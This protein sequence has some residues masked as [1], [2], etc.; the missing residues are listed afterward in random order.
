MTHLFSGTNIEY[1]HD[2]ITRQVFSHDA[3]NYCIEPKGVVFPK[4]DTEVMTIIAKA[5]EHQLS[6]IPRGAATG[7][8]GGCLGSGLI[9][10]TSKHMNQILEINR[11]EGWVKC[12]PGV[13]Q[14]HLN[15]ALSP[16]RLGPDTSTGNRATIG[17]MVGNNAAGSYSL[18]YGQMIDHVLEIEMALSTGKLI[19]FKNPSSTLL[20]SLRPYQ[21]EIERRFPKIK[22]HVSGYNLDHFLQDPNPCKLIVGSEGT[23][24][25]ITAIK[26]K[27]VPRP[28]NIKLVTIPF[29]SLEKAFSAIPD[30]LDANPLAIELID[31]TILKLAKSPFPGNPE[32]ILAIEYD[33]HSLPTPF[34]PLSEA[35]RTAFW[36]IRHNGLGILLSKKSYNR[37]IAFFEDPALPPEKLPQF[38]KILRQ[39][40]KR[41]FGLYGHVGAGCLHLRPFVDLKDPTEIDAMKSIMLQLTHALI[42]LGGT[43]SSEHGDGLVRSW[44]N[45]TFYGPKI[46][47]AF[48]IV[49][50][51]FDPHNIMNP[52]KIVAPSPFE[53]NLKSPL[54]TTLKTHFD[55]TSEGGIALAV[56]MCNGNGQCRKLDGVMCPSYQ[57]TR[58]EKETTRA[59]ANALQYALR[60]GNFSSPDLHEVLDL[61]LS[62]KGCKTECPSHIDMAKLKSEY[63]ATQPKSFRDHL[64]ANPDKLLPYTPNFLR[65]LL[66]PLLGIAH[67]LPKKSPQRFT[68]W[69]S[70]QTQP[71]NLSKQVVLI[72]DTFTEFFEP[73]IGKAAVAL[74]NLLGYHVI[75]PPYACCGRPA[76]SKGFLPQAKQRAHTLV[77]NLLP[78]AKQNLPF[79]SLEPS[80]A[81]ALI[82]DYCDLLPNP[83]TCTTQTIEQFL[84][85]HRL[86]KTPPLILHNHCHNKHPPSL[87]LPITPLPTG[88]CGMAGAFGYETE[89]APLSHT[90]AKHTLLP[91]LQ[92]IPKGHL[93]IANG[94]SCRTQISLYTPHR[95]LHLVQ[96]FTAVHL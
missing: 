91:H 28:K 53:K 7:L 8:T 22:R 27:I 29:S 33:E 25:I 1:R 20:D 89:H 69:F 54:T 18:R 90:I 26:L 30:L 85:G 77:H 64:F 83:I 2:S 61:C 42:E 68:H 88:C 45:E 14:D 11:D 48:Q 46:I 84:Q 80:C 73:Q 21:S 47:E 95:P 59:R 58:D 5:K 19:R 9:V 96:A 50:Q 82:D 10:D 32:A 23:L 74:F 4:S 37:A 51:A 67:P 49:K 15:Q 3:S 66:N 16:Y 72:V 76:I 86:P 65:N 71:T 57:A 24:G 41:P 52:G 87:P 35:E 13:V 17:G 40:L 93:L 70:R 60:T 56:D 92:N 78:Y 62:C 12:Q 6:L 38:L 79:V 34:T 63:L 44:L 55:F 81:S 75:V 31:H 36:K 39:T 94:F 43:P